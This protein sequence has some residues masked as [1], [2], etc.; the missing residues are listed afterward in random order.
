MGQNKSASRPCEFITRSILPDH[1]W[2]SGIDL[3]YI[4][5]PTFSTCYMLSY[6]LYVIYYAYMQALVEKD[7]L[8]FGHPFADRAGMPSL[9][10]SGSI[11]LELSRHASSPNITS[12]SSPSSSSSSSSSIRQLSTLTSQAPVSNVQPS[13]SY[14]PIFLQ[15]CFFYNV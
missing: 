14:S 5:F 4:L 10:G 13:N 6:L 3:S 9:S 12:P 7:W 8:A 11:P 15:A 2:I 1:K